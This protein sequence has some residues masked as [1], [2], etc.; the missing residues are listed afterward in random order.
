MEGSK[1]F[2]KDFMARHGIPTAK[3][4]VFQSREFE[5]AE[6]YVRES[7][8]I[9]EGAVIKAS[10]LAGG[11]GVLIPQNVEEAVKG[12]KEVML[13]G[14]FGDAGTSFVTLFILQLISS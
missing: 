12:L 6:K 14:I 9:W 3:F 13:D 4:K 10:G 7:W 8:D 1:A 11:K 2:S 5:Q